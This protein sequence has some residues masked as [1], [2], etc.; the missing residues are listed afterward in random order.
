MGRKS[1]IIFK[2]GGGQVKSAIMYIH[3]Q[4]NLSLYL[5]PHIPV[6][7]ITHSSRK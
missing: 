3:A 2:G 5:I 7:F 4:N 6:I 1:E